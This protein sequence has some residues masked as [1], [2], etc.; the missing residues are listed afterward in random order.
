MTYEEFQTKILADL[1]NYY[2]ADA[3]IEIKTVTKNNGNIYTGINIHLA[4]D[5]NIVPVIYLER[6]YEMYEQGTCIDECVEK[7]IALR[8]ESGA[9]RLGIDNPLET[10]T[11]WEVVKDKVYPILIN[12][13]MNQ[14][15]LQRLVHKQF[16]D[17][18]VVYIIRLATEENGGMASVKVT[19]ELIRTYGI[20]IDELHATALN[21]L[22]NDNYRLVDMEIVIRQMLG[23][24][25]DE[26]MLQSL[27][28]GK[29]YL[30]SNGCKQYGAAGMLY[31]DFLKEKSNGQSFY[32]LPSSIH[33]TIFIPVSED[34][35]AEELNAMVV[36]VNESQVEAGEVLSNHTYYYDGAS[37]ELRIA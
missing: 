21:N 13:E 24:I 29:M 19:S 16:L 1:R 10:I 6:Y 27:E 5:G 31:D 8:E 20:S 14:D 23:D 37:G 7:I 11:T 12:T 17:L 15:L 25:N 34:V 36:E 35:K 18:S 9:D 26:P 33:E 30:L 32:I 28:P 3:K 4:E 2:G 22:Q